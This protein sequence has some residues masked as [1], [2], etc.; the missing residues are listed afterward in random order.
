LVQLSE[1]ARAEAVR[2]ACAL[3]NGEF[4]RG[5][6]SFQ[7]GISDLLVVYAL[8][9]PTADNDAA[10]SAAMVS[11]ILVAD[12]C[13]R[14]PRPTRTRQEAVPTGTPGKCELHSRQINA[15][16]C[17]LM[18]SFWCEAE[19]SAAYD[20]TSDSVA[21]GTVDCVARESTIQRAV[22][23]YKPVSSFGAK[24]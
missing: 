1:V 19:A 15:Y 17:D 16:A 11:A 9:Q 21:D 2:C 10:T 20:A 6:S 22:S 3:F 18:G 5:F 14:G 13:R 7:K 23:G 24:P 8:T 4:A 12:G